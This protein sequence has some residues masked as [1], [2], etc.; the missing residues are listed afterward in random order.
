MRYK[1]LR[2]P[3]LTV[4]KCGFHRCT[5]CH[6]PSVGSNSANDNPH[7]C[8]VW[9][10]A[11]KKSNA[12]LQTSKLGDHSLQFTPNKCAVFFL[13]LN[14]FTLSH[15]FFCI[16]A[17]PRGLPQQCLQVRHGIDRWSCSLGCIERGLEVQI[18]QLHEAGHTRRAGTVAALTVIPSWQC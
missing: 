13:I 3:L 10:H 14:S 18:A 1:Q 17:P 12:D 16:T 15:G 7:C 5:T 6:H 9:G 4:D 2:I 8:L 11:P